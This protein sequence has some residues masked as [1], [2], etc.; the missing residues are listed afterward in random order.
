M[1]DYE[2][3]T[4]RELDAAVAERLMGWTQIHPRD[5]FGDRVGTT[6]IPPNMA[7]FQ[8]L[9]HYSTDDNAARLVRDRIAELGL[10]VYFTECLDNIVGE[11]SNVPW[12]HMQS[13]P[14]QQCIAAL[15]ALEAKA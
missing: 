14:R 3:L 6:G 12:A 5:D 11:V 7:G 1:S 15:M 13:T 2:K 4:N 9:K 10:V 8:Y